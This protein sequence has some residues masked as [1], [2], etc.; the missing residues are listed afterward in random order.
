MDQREVIATDRSSGPNV[1]P[2]HPPAKKNKDADVLQT[3]L[4]RE[5][6]LWGWY[7]PLS[8]AALTPALA[9]A[10]WR[11]VP[12]MS[13]PCSLDYFLHAS[14]LWKC[15]IDLKHTSRWH[16]EQ[17]SSPQKS[18]ELLLCHSLLQAK[19]APGDARKKSSKLIIHCFID[20]Q[21]L[22]PGRFDKEA[23]SFSRSN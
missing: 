20:F 7:C 9:G 5:V 4:S 19:E 13:R 14:F 2:W 21:L 18:C 8:L 17:T 12:S 11:N 6:G 23:W 15:S 10:G 22:Q 3:N 16:K 1:S